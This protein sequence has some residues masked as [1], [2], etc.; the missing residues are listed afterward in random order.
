[1]IDHTLLKADATPGQITHLC[2]EA[3]TY[4]FASVC[5]NASF[6]SLCK[7]LLEG[8]GVD[9]CTV[10]GFPLGA[11]ST[12]SKACEAEQ[13]LRDG[14]REIDMV[15]HIG[16]LKACSYAYVLADIAAVAA[17]AHSRDAILKV[18]LETCLLSD[19]EKMKASLL[20]KRAGADFVKTSTGFSTGGATADDI[21]LMR[22]V[23]GS[24]VGVKASGGI[25]TTDDALKM[26][27]A[28][29]SRI[30]ASAGIAILN[31]FQTR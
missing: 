9:V 1:M 8:S 24:V 21:L 31:G 15:I 6:V 30:G 18:I 19:E 20:A 13:A 25:R 12:A 4:K 11:T 26:V 3:R 28:G 17:V 16:L 23:V 7:E 2:N 5:V 10:V 14:A 27:R 29:A 22:S